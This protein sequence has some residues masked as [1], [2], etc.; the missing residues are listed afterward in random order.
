MNIENTL[1]K[2]VYFSVRAIATAFAFSGGVAG[3][4]EFVATI[5]FCA[6]DPFESEP[7][8]GYEQVSKPSVAEFST[9]TS[10]T[11]EFG[12]AESFEVFRAEVGP[13]SQFSYRYRQDGT[14]FYF[15]LIEAESLP[16][17]FSFR[18]TECPMAKG[19][20]EVE[21]FRLFARDKETV[22]FLDLRGL[23]EGLTNEV[24]SPR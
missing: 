24:E 20:D 8:V 3:A 15:G 14:F 21:L 2:I 17:A 23:M 5:T 7:I 11:V 9:N 19:G 22:F 1:V 18:V 16:V 12:E 13:G 4:E 10:I 6:G